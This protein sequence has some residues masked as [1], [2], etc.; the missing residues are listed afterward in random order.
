M[1]YNKL[2]IYNLS[3]ELFIETHRLSF[4][5]PKYE[6]YE[7]GSQLRR[8]SDSVNSNIV[9]GYGRRSY[10]ADYLRFLVFSHSSCDETTNHLLEITRLY[11]DITEFNEI[12]EK[13]KLL[14][15]KLHNYTEYVKN[16]WR[17]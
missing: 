7:L 11:P 8:S 10:K 6:L 17:S 3:F 2:D 15:G 16:N 9:E 5:L 13:Y 4:R 12:L 14:G 1:S